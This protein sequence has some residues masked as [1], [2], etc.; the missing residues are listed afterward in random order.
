MRY[1][2]T[3]AQLGNPAWLA[4]DDDKDGLSN[5]SELVAGT[6]PFTAGSTILISSATK[7]GANIDLRFPTVPG[8]QYVAQAS[9]NLTSPTWA[10]LG[11]PLTGDGTT[12]TI[13][14]PKF[15]N[16]SYFY[17]VQVLDIDTD[18]DQVSD[19]AERVAGND[20]TTA[21]TAGSTTDDH[22][23]LVAGVAGSNVV[24]VVA[25][26]VTATQPPDAA[27]PPVDTGRIVVRRSGPL[28]F[29]SITVPLQKA[30]TATEGTDYLALPASVTFPVDAAEVFLDVNPKANLARRT[31]VTALVKALA[32]LGYTL[33]GT[34]SGSVVIFPAG[35]TNGTGLT[36][37]YHNSSA[38]DY[39]AQTAIFNG[40]AELS[41]TD[42]TINFSSGA[43]GW[44]AVAG[45]TGMS[46][47]ST[48]RA[49]SVRWTGQ[50][51]PEYSETY[52]IDFRSDDSAKVWVNGRLLI[53]RWTTQAA[54]DYLNT[55]DLEAGVLYDIQIDYWN[56][57]ASTTAEAKLYW[58][59]ASQVKE[60][61]PRSRLFP[62][63]AQANKFTAITSAIDVIG[64]A[65]TPLTYSLTS[66]DI[67]GTVTYALDANSAALPPGL[68]LN[69]ATGVISGAPTLAG[70]YNCAINAT[71]TAAGGSGAARSCSSPS[72]RWVVSLAK[73]SR[74]RAAASPA[75]CCRMATPATPPSR[76]RMT[77]AT[78]PIT[79][80]SGCADTLSRPRRA[81]TTSGSPRTT[82][83]S[84]ISPTT[85]RR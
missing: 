80:A 58:W 77:I 23:S 43:N 5:G 19:W 51:L 54:T 2:V 6:N 48:N 69:G 27:T 79:P 66:P 4:A 75:S 63:P 30:G 20:P 83:P 44:G 84:C 29:N 74:P 10:A 81:T 9:P 78:I 32:G 76:P 21:N 40:A 35:R 50:I 14:V 46:P 82:R 52:T 45:P 11:T 49:F 3:P 67:G 33:G 65:G 1:G 53:D 72:I 38:A 7:N 85:P 25:T 26:E 31:N 57:A 37:R 39:T 59:S 18:N 42:T 17:R 12:R 60:I 62:A 15:A 56:A 13:P 55:I 68:S 22:T 70:S 16:D 71:N 61:I 34:T 73:C 28:L 64:Y 36:A 47:A 24:T 41:R 8:K